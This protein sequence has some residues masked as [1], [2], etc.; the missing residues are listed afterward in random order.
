M[1]KWYVSR[2]SY[3]SMGENAL[4]VEI[5]GGGRDYSNPGQLVSKYSGEAE[6]YTDPRE[7]VKVA[8]E[9][10]SQWRKDLRQA[11]E[12]RKITIRRGHTGGFTMPFEPTTIKEATDWAEETYEEL[13]KCAGCGG[14]LGKETWTPDGIDDPDLICCSER[15]AEKLI[16]PDLELEE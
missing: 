11:G 14:L 7:A 5:A 8:T 13:P 6:E 9:I 15:C 4:V 2:Q 1:Q 3:S 10:A 16:E 12:H